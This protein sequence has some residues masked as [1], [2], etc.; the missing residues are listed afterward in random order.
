M[1]KINLSQV[2]RDIMQNKNIPHE[3]DSTQLDLAGWYAYY[4]EQIIPLEIAQATF[5][6]KF[7]GIDTEKPKSD[8]FVRALWKMSQEGKDMVEIER[9]LKTIHILISSIKASLNR[10]TNELRNK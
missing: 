6:E 3:L 9:T 8:P 10:Q 5:W 7:K 1:K 4:S 2:G